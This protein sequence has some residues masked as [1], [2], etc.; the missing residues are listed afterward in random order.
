[1]KNKKYDITFIGS[2][3]SCTYTLLHLINITERAASVKATKILIIERTGEF[4]TG[5]P[6]GV[7]SG[8]NALIIT[9]LKDF[10][11][12][13]ERPVF[14]NWLIEKKEWI[15]EELVKRG[16]ILLKDWLKENIKLFEAE[17]WDSIYIPRF[18][19]GVFLTERINSLIY[20]EKN[21]SSFKIELVKAEVQNIFPAD[22]FYIVK[23]KNAKKTFLFYSEKVILSIG[24]PHQ[25]LQTSSPEFY[26][27]DP[28]HP[29]ID[30][31]MIAVQKRLRA[32]PYGRNIMIIGSNASALEVLYHF[33]GSK[34][35][36]ELTQ[37][38]YILSTSG[39]FPYR[40]SEGR[41][42]DYK[43][44][45]LSSLNS[46]QFNTAKE[47][48]EALKKD[49][50]TAEASN[51]NIADTVSSI[52]VNI[53]RLLDRLNSTEQKKFVEKY[54]VEIGKLQRRAGAAYYDT[55]AELI[56]RGKLEFIKGR[57]LKCYLKEDLLEVKYYD[58]SSNE[59][60]IFPSPIA[61]MINCTG[62]QSLTKPLP[63]L[64]GLIKQKICRVNNS[65]RGI[66]VNENFEA[67]KNFYV[68]GP[69]L[70]G[71]LNKN[72]RVW[73]AESCPRIFSLSRQLAEILVKEYQTQP[74]TDIFA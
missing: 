27:A 66:E 63:L 42:I 2:G 33:K 23:G 46:A 58:V 39:K 24:S 28:Y 30:I 21:N 11:P 45:H 56:N 67:S 49:I 62:F 14:R 55:A 60:K 19:F 18:L 31:N 61:V 16:G 6:Y 37:R 38:V 40:I 44:L 7:R 72:I 12:P 22:G 71:N 32:V 29:G 48:L 70:A 54:G 53:L 57:F 43:P 36:N 20:S 1:M 13:D 17:D 50:K 25:Q 34:S 52:S 51:I 10:L 8:Y 59:E 9:A 35:I 68:M 41:L 5:V 69:L 64:Q 4:W 73:H 47:I 3:L 15:A 65:K 74:E 26:I